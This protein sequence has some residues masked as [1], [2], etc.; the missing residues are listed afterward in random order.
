M[1]SVM[2]SAPSNRI[3]PSASLQIIVPVPVA[4]KVAF[5]PLSIVTFWDDGI[6][7]LLTV[8]VIVDTPAVTVNNA[9]I[10]QGDSA[11]LTANA[12]LTGGTFT[13]S[14]GQTGQSITVAPSLT[15]TYTVTYTLSGC[16]P[17]AISTVTVTPAPTISVNDLTICDG[18]QATLTA[19]A[20]QPGGV[21]TWSNGSN[22]NSISV[23]PSSTTSYSVSYSLGSC[24]IDTATATHDEEVDGTE[25]SYNMSIVYD[26]NKKFTNNLTVAKTYIKRIYAGYAGFLQDISRI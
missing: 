20:S 21:F 18:E 16:S 15:S 13:W 9:N 24:S 7:G 23:S 5:S 4:F 12:T 19:S 8:T 25:A 6:S 14:N 26:V 10:C 2:K 3:L 22:S 17:S 1:G 11:I